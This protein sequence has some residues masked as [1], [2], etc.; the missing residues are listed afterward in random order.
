[1]TNFIQKTHLDIS[2]SAF[3]C[4]LDSQSSLLTSQILVSCSKFKWSNRAYAV[5]WLRGTLLYPY[6]VGKMVVDNLTNTSGCP[7]LRCFNA[8]K[9]LG[10][11]WVL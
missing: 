9:C 1:M 10:T 4:S 3:N 8:P 5:Y 6:I 7:E 2:F 11:H